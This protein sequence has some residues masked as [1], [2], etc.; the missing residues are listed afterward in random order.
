MPQ[1]KQPSIYDLRGKFQFT[2]EKLWFRL[3]IY[4]VTAIFWLGVVYAL[5][6]WSIPALALK[7]ISGASIGN[8]LK[9]KGQS[10]K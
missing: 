10:Q 5:R 1:Q 4:V 7:G 9:L 6:E 3:V 2:T 8:I